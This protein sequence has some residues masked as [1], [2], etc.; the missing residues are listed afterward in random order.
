MLT[1][2]ESA[3]RHGAKTPRSARQLQQGVGD[4]SKARSDT[5]IAK[6]LARVR[7]HTS[8]SGLTLQ[9]SDQERLVLAVRRRAQLR[10]HLLAQMPLQRER[11]Q[12]RERLARDLAVGGKLHLLVSTRAAAEEGVMETTDGTGG[13]CATC[14]RD[15]D[16][17]QPDQVCAFC[18][19]NCS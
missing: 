9:L 15:G 8:A 12:V 11:V 6:H 18:H 10:A 4:I 14:D 7:G 2:D 17:D 5:A 13:E 16:G 19:V 1:C 3:P